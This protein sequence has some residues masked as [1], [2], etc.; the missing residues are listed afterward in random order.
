MSSAL[1]RTMTVK[2][3]IPPRYETGLRAS[4]P[5]LYF[6]HPWGLSPR[7]ITDKLRIAVHLWEGVVGGALPPMIIVVPEGG[8]SFFVNAADPPGHDWSRIVEANPGF[9]EDAL[10]QY[11]RY[12]D[13]IW[14]D[15]IPFVESHYRVRTDGSGRA[16]GGI[17]MGGAA[18]AVH[19]FRSPA[20]FAAV[21]MHSPALFAGHPENA[22]PPWIFG[23]NGAGFA[24]RNP[25]DCA[26]SLEPDTN[27]RIYLDTGDEDAM[28][29]EVHNLHMVL[30]ERHMNHAYVVRP[31]GHNKH[32]WEPHMGEYLAFYGKSW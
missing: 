24:A 19:A 14:Q 5:V 13:Y 21:G 18:A 3:V 7:Y 26:L 16:I 11:G 27:L 29:H 30:A 8:K 31:G 20:A 15:V 32:Y 23:L 2:V 6:L 1:T 28:L 10:T 25:A 22:G 12:G 9:F 17:S 4:Y